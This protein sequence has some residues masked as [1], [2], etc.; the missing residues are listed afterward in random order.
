MIARKKI[1]FY[2]T[3]MRLHK[4][5][6]FLLLL[7]PTLWGL[8]L[9]NNGR[10]PLVLFGIFTA[11]TFLMRAAG[12]AVN[13]IADRHIDPH[14]AR[15]KNRPLAS[16]AI[17]TQE[18][19]IIALFLASTAFILV[20]F[21]NTL[22]IKLS[23]IGALLA[24]VYPFLKR[25]T[26][27]PQVGLGIAFA[28]G[29]PMAFAASQNTMPPNAWI[30]FTTAL[31]WPIIYDTFYAMADQSDDQKHG[32]KSTAI[33][34][35]GHVQLITALLQGLFLLMLVIVGH[36]F[37]LSA[38]YYVSLGV[39]LLLFLYQ[40]KLLAQHDPAKAFNAFLNNQWVGLAIFLGIVGGCK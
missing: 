21:C 16:G 39:V 36:L 35:G 26:H 28:W 11:G 22:T 12:C 8:W 14:V 2:L 4:P 9:A 38:V 37:I 25:I 15:T 17:S 19:V 27:L 18:A 1:P 7:W 30:L 29:I 33:L 10:P 3:L 31:L 6:G 34:F 23:F 24:T 5:V 13:D 32:V 40:Q 20:L